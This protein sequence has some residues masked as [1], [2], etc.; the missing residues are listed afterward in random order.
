[1]IHVAP[2]HAEHVEL[3]V[4]VPAVAARDFPT[5]ELYLAV[6]E[7]HGEAN[8]GYL[9]GRMPVGYNAT[10][11]CSCDDFRYNRVDS[12]DGTV[13]GPCKHIEAVWKRTRRTTEPDQT[14]L[15]GAD[16]AE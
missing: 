1:M 2:L 8:T 4:S 7:Q 12:T 13:T 10:H 14:T 11:W 3:E 6:S 16:D 15:G 9:V 5:D